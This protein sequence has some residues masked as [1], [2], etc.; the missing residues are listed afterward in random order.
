MST[1]PEVLAARHCGMKIL[2]LSLITNKVVMEDVGSSKKKKVEEMHATHEEVLGA[3][4]D[5][6]MKVESLVR[7]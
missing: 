5:S 4:K 1:I 3:V 7:V 2:G 6:G